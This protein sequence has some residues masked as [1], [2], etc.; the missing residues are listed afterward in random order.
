VAASRVGRGIAGC[1]AGE[2]DPVA[3]ACIELLSNPSLLC[4]AGV[5]DTTELFN[6]YNGSKSYNDV[7]RLLC[8]SKRLLFDAAAQL[9]S[10]ACSTDYQIDDEVVRAGMMFNGGDESVNPGVTGSLPARP[11]AAGQFRWAGAIAT[12]RRTTAIPA[13][14]SRFRLTANL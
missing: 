6:Q 11:A 2:V 13:P 5:Y 7:C 10:D 9:P 1:V 8:G 4:A 12:M 3:E 14:T